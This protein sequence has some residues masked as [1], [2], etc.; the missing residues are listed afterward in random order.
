[1]AARG[2]SRDPTTGEATPEEGPGQVCPLSLLSFV[3]SCSL[4]PWSLDSTAL[5]IWGWGAQLRL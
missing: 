4:S 2:A 1:M 3:S 5:P